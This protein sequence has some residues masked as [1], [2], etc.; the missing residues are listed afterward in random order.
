MQNVFRLVQKQI[1]E[2]LGFVRIEFE[3]ETFS[4]VPESKFENNFSSFAAESQVQSRG[5][6]NVIFPPEKLFNRGQIG[7][8]SIGLN[9]GLV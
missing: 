3:S 4:R 7:L 9:K 8:F 1:S 5:K 6:L 2:S